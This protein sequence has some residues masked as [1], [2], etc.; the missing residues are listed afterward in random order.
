MTRSPGQRMTRPGRIRLRVLIPGIDRGATMSQTTRNAAIALILIF[1]T[2]TLRAQEPSGG[3]LCR[4]VGRIRQHRS[5]AVRGGSRG[6]GG[7]SRGAVGGELRLQRLGPL[8]LRRD[9]EPP[10]RRSRPASGGLRS[11]SLVLGQPE[12]RGAVPPGDRPPRQSLRG[13]ELRLEL[14]RCVLG[15]PGL[16]ALAGPPPEHALPLDHALRHRVRPGAVLDA[17]RAVGPCSFGLRTCWLR[18]ARRCARRG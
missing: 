9:P 16:D 7:G 5:P 1:A 11:R 4:L 14:R 13:A 6:R 2:T 12:Q 3:P 8:R 17:Q 10:P 18:W 15:R